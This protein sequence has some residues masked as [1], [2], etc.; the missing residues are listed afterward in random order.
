MA[1]C[2]LR[3]ML[4]RIAELHLRDNDQRDPRLRS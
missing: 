2:S 1:R 3:D 4:P